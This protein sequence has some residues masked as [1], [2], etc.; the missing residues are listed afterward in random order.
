MKKLLSVF[1]AVAL[2]AACKGKTADANT[3]AAT[4][5][6]PATNAP[7]PAPAADTKIAFTNSASD[8]VCQYYGSVADLATKLETAAEKEKDAILKEIAALDEKKPACLTTGEAEEAK[9]TASMSEAEKEAFSESLQ[10]AVEKKC[11]DAVA[12]INKMNEQ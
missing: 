9:L 7:A 12:A 8:C 5:T 11:P 3:A 1:A 4:T 10:A 6:T 2:L